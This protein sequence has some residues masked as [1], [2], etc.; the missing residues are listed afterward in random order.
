MHTVG[1]PLLNGCPTR[2]PGHPS[3]GAFGPSRILTKDSM[4]SPDVLAMQAGVSTALATFQGVLREQRRQKS[5]A[6]VRNHT[7]GDSS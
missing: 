4:Q 3:N 7:N 2:A 5:K 1:I 6:L